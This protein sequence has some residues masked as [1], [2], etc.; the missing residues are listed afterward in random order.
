MITNNEYNILLAIWNAG[1]P[2][3]AK[4]IVDSIEDK[5]FKD[6]TIHSLLNAMLDA[7]LIYVDG[8]KLSTKIYSRCFNTKLSF[9]EF[10]A[11]QIK[12]NAVYRREKSDVLPGILSALMEDDV[13][14]DTLDKLESLLQE[15][16]RQMKKQP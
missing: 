7:G 12:E 8:Q 11:E 1:H 14:S 13:S 3:T 2:L 4:E 9:E 5:S 10:Q 6:R 16:R 15:K